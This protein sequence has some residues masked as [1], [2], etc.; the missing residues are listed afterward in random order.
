LFA[1]STAVLIVLIGLPTVVLTVSSPPP[2][3][4][5]EWTSRVHGHRCASWGEY[6]KAPTPP[7][8]LPPSGKPSGGG[9]VKP[10][11]TSPGGDTLNVSDVVVGSFNNSDWQTEYVSPSTGAALYENCE[12]PLA[13]YGGAYVPFCAEIALSDAKDGLRNHHGQQR[14]N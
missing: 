2:P 13:T 1:L 9:G 4:G 6:A 12:T 8:V 11:V 14:L 3:P 5:T 10:L 7:K